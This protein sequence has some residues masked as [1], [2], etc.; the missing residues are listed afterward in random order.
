MPYLP[1]VVWDYLA[2]RQSQEVAAK[3]REIAW[4]R[5]ELASAYAQQRRIERK[6][7]RLPDRETRPHEP[8][9]EVEKIPEDI[10]ALANLFAP[11]TGE[12]VEGIRETRKDGTTWQEVKEGLVRSLP[13]AL[14]AELEAPEEGG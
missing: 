8:V 6:Q 4:L 9:P 1:K 5:G 14:R 3:D 11:A 10:M 2:S 7:Q 12:I 13:P